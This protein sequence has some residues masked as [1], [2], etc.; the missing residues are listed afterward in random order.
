M[1]VAVYTTVEVAVP[2]VIARPLLGS[3]LV[4]AH[5]QKHPYWRRQILHILLPLALVEMAFQ[6]QVAGQVAIILCLGVSHPSVVD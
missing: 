4:A 1:A 6:A 2:A 3:R 5:L